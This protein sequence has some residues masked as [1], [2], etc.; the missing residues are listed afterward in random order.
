MRIKKEMLRWFSH[1]ERLDEVTKKIIYGKEGIKRLYIRDFSMKLP[2][3]IDK[4]K[5]NIFE[6]N[7]Y[8]FKSKYCPCISAIS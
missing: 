3:Y 2:V 4:L 7:K 5:P 8:L 6:E 1:A